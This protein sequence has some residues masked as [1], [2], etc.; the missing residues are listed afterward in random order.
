MEEWS[1]ERGRSNRHLA[2]SLVAWHEW[3]FLR[4]GGTVLGFVVAIGLGIVAL[5]AVIVA[6]RKTVPQ[7]SSASTRRSRRTARSTWATA[8]VPAVLRS[9]RRCRDS[10][11]FP[12]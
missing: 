9:R 1:P 3:S 8:R 10:S 11:K 5:V 12:R 6:L 4:G 2:D 7:E